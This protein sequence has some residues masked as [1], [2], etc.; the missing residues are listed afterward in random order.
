MLSLQVLLLRQG[1]QNRKIA[2][3]GDVSPVPSPVSTDDY[4]PDTAIAMWD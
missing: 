1:L 3:V 2:D 4:N